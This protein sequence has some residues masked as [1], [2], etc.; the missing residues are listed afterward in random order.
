MNPNP[1]EMLHLYQIWILPNQKDITPR[2]AQKAFAEHNGG[3]LILSPTAEQGSFKVYQDMCLWR[4]QLTNG[5][6]VD[7]PLQTHRCYWLQMTKGEIHLADL[8]LVAGDGL[9]ISQE[10][11]LSITAK[12]A[13]QNSEFLLFDL[14]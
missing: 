5:Q 11:L 8:H 6:Q 3:T 10:Q 1:D 13:V 2:Y 7:I 12:S 4:W 9:A 14:A